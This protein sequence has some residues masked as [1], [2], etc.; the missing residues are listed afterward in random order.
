MQGYHQFVEVP[1]SRLRLRKEAQNIGPK[2]NHCCQDP[3]LFFMSGKA[4]TCLV[5]PYLQLGE[6]HLEEGSTL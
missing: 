5:S 6:W 2:T 3:E 4:K 1:L